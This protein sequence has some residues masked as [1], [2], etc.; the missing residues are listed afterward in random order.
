MELPKMA[1]LS[2]RNISSKGWRSKDDYDYLYSYQQ[3]QP[4]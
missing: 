4:W 1:S 2:I 3:F